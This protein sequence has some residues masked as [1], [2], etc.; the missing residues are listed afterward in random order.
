MLQVILLAYNLGPSGIPTGCQEVANLKYKTVLILYL[1]IKGRRHTI[2]N[3]HVACKFLL[4]KIT[5]DTQ[6]G[7]L[8][9]SDRVSGGYRT[10]LI[11]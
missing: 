10:K 6:V 8:G 11:V 4:N 5:P 7:A 2:L 3:R 1:H 9:A